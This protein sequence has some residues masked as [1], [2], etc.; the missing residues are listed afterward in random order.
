MK[1]PPLL[2]K[3]LKTEKDG[4]VTVFRFKSLDDLLKAF[5]RRPDIAAMFAEC[6]T[7]R[8]VVK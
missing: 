4:T 8:L 2:P 6:G 1:T 3:K 5:E 7:V